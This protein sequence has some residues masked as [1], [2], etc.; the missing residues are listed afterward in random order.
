MNCT[1]CSMENIKTFHI[2]EWD[3]YHI[4][5]EKC[6]ALLA[7]KTYFDVVMDFIND[8][9]EVSPPIREQAS[10]LYQAYAK[11]A[12]QNNQPLMTLTKFG[13]VLSEDFLIRQP[14][15]LEKTATSRCLYYQGLK[16][17]EKGE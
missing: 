3:G 7:R 2:K 14:F 17:K 16:L 11:W 1:K 13:R 9:C 4:R 8:C 12:E 6:G 15:F 5:C 10:N